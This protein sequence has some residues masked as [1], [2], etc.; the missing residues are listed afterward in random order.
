MRMPHSPDD[1]P[2]GMLIGHAEHPS[3]H[4]GA[5]VVLTPGGAVGGVAVRGGAP[6]T[7]ETD[8]L[9][10]GNRVDRVHGVLLTG[11]SAFG[12]A[13]A[14]GVVRWLLERGSG[15]PTAA[16]P[17][18]I[19]PA[20]VLYDLRPGALAWPDAATGYAACEAATSVWPAEGLVG[21]G[22]GTTVGKI[23]GMD[24]SS[25][26]GIGAAQVELDGVV[27]GAIMAVNALG[28]VVEPRTNQIVAGARHA[29][30]S[31]VD[32]VDQILLGPAAPPTSSNTTIGVIWTNAALDKQG[33]NRIAEVA[34]NGLARTIRP[35]HTQYDGDT[36][37]VLALSQERVGT[38]DWSR[39]GVAAT[40]AVARAVVRAVTAG[41]L[42]A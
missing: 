21:A 31:W 16:G 42:D 35:A 36:L 2:P 18:P 40:E 17:V 12:L 41:H 32:T 19:V 5:T 30:G 22:R 10:S 1:L 25:P 39:L 38:A 15:W 3:G 28:H 9:R 26:G 27:V 20:A 13:A 8:L 14:D 11:G 37:F 7:R 34:H 23:L 29:D 6:G 4:T 24:L 33:C